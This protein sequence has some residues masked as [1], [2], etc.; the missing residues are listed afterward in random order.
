M[1][2]FVLDHYLAV[3]GVHMV[4]GVCKKDKLSMP[5]TVYH[6]ECFGDP[7]DNLDHFVPSLPNLNH[8]I[9][10]LEDK[11]DEIS[12]ITFGDPVLLQEL[13]ADL[14]Q[15]LHE[16]YRASLMS[17][18]RMYKFLQTSGINQCGSTHDHHNL[19]H[20]VMEDLSGKAQPAPHLIQHHMSPGW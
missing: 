9:R 10:S 11:C 17:W 18:L 19:I 4:A 12:L 13:L 16:S 7:L 20:W 15:V 6:P 3:P 14:V 8:P 2:V 1:I 5:G